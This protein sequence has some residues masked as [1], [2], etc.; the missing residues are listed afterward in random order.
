MA[1]LSTTMALGIL[2]GCGSDGDVTRAPSPLDAMEMFTVAGLPVT[3]G[4]SGPRADAPDADLAVVGSD[5]SVVDRLATNA[6]ADLQ[7]YWADRFRSEFQAEFV[8]LGRFVSYDSGGPGRTVCGSSTEGLVNAF[9]CPAEDTIA[10]DRGE[11]LPSFSETFGPMSVVLVLAHETGHAVQTRLGL[12]D[13]ATPTIVSEQQ[14]D[15][16]AGAFFRHVAVGDSE[17]FEI[18]TGPGIGQV[19]ASVFS[20]RDPTEGV[21]VAPGAHGNA[22]DRVSAF[23]FGF[24][25][26]PVRCARIDTADVTQRATQFGFGSQQE[27]ASG[28]DVAISRENLSQ[29][30]RSLDTAFQAGDDVQPQVA[31]QMQDCSEARRTPVA[32]YC[33]A[34]NT[35]STDLDELTR[36]GAEASPDRGIGDFA[37]FAVYASRY[38]LAIQRA[39]G[40]PL[41]D[42]RAGLTTA[43]LV[44]AWSGVLL[45]TPFGNRDPIDD[46]PIR[47]AAGDLDEA[48]AE[49]LSDGLI[50]SGVNGE[51]VPSSFARVEAFRMGFLQGSQPCNR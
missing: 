28:G 10:W 39:A 47:L 38:A 49:L 9:Y 2:A 16:F 50:A 14:A 36:L 34:T 37:A 27:A 51:T 21:L 17:H 5:G 35:I 31:F 29:V 24:A 41:D 3:D 48:V 44:G 20:L 33:P 25:E 7:A 32:A 1:V 11:L 22:F 19:L 40:W 42:E 43:C 8:P 45:D 6:M 30:D 23:Q 26:G 15:C 46:P 4:P 12:V 13:Q 18:S